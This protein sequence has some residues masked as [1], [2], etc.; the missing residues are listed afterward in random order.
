MEK[1]PVT[2][3]W[4]HP[5]SAVAIGSDQDTELWTCGTT[6]ARG[7]RSR[8]RAS[9]TDKKI[10][11]GVSPVLD[12]RFMPASTSN[13]TSPVHVATL[14]LTGAPSSGLTCG[15]GGGV[16]A[17]QERADL[18]HGL[19]RQVYCSRLSCKH[20]PWARN[21]VCCTVTTGR[22]QPQGS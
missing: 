19:C 11:R 21:S 4:A 18:I 15:D 17:G 9:P 5:S 2:L 7:H 13:A 12:C 1:H 8:P 3:K 16:G 6:T 14:T 20:I 10:Q 22:V